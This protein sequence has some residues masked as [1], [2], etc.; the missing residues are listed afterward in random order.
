MKYFLLALVLAVISAVSIL[1][2]RGDKT[3]NRPLEIFPDMDDQSKY[4]PQTES[5]F[6][7]DGRSDRLPVQGAIARGFLKDDDH[8]HFGKD[9]DAW[10]AGFPEQIVINNDLMAKGQNKYTVYCSMCH[11]GVGDG[12]GVTKTRGMIVT[13]SYHNNRL[14]D[15]TDGEIFNTITNG[16]GLM[17]YY[18]DKLS[19]EERWAVIAYVRALQR[20]QH[21]SVDDV[22][23]AERK[24]LGL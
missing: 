17:G 13:P 22:P 8:L 14:R 5:D 7:A 18:K 1:G 10:A 12:N 4:K 16:K 9:G 20:S 11:G 19:V 21:A 23:Q 3:T 15:M 6:F 24:D 2:F